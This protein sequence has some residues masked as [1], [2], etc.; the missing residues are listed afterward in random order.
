MLAALDRARIGRFL[1]DGGGAAF[2]L[3]AR[4]SVEEHVAHVER[5]AR[6][7]APLVRPGDRLVD[8]GCGSGILGFVGA[9]A[10][11]DV[12]W[13][14]VDARAGAAAFAARGVS[15]LGLG[16][17]SVTC[18]RAEA[19]ARDDRHAYDGVVARRFGK[20]AHTAECGAPLLKLGGFLLVSDASLPENADPARPPEDRWP[21]EGLALLGLCVEARWLDHLVVRAAAACDAKFPRSKRLKKHLF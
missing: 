10:F 21:A 6:H 17:V 2:N 16:N 12:H 14:L 7:L 18:A 13:T 15:D 5:L 3:G 9:M 8:L 11:P 4:F 20:P 19:L 1:V